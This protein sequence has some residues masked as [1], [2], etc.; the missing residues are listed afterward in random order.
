MRHTRTRAADGPCARHAHSH[1]PRRT[2]GCFGRATP[3]FQGRVRSWRRCWTTLGS[4]TVVRWVH[5][6]KAEGLT[7]LG[8]NQAASSSDEASLQQEQ[9]VDAQYEAWR[10]ARVKDRQL[11]L[12]ECV[13]H[14]PTMRTRTQCQPC[15]PC[16]PCQPCQ[17]CHASMPVMP[18]Q[19]T[20]TRPAHLDLAGC[21]GCCGHRATTRPARVGPPPRRAGTRCV[22]RWAPRA[23]QRRRHHPCR[24]RRARGQGATRS[25]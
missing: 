15:R 2:R 7:E 1:P 9:E 14:S 18:C 4:V 8:F 13:R 24:S 23:R 20:S 17:P 21:G 16:R 11:E 3:G 25:G 10:L 19:M 22:T 12:E 6:E 5:A